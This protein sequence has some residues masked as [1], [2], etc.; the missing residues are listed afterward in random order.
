MDK[1]VIMLGL[2]FVASLFLNA[3]LLTYLREL[4]RDNKRYRDEIR[5]LG[6]KLYGGN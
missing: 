2:I 5:K 1:H 4:R 3:F 6:N